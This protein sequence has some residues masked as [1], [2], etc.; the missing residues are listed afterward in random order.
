M[1]SHIKRLLSLV[2]ASLILVT[3]A[4]GATYGEQRDSSE[5]DVSHQTQLCAGAWLSETTPQSENY[6][7]YKPNTSTVPVVAYGNKL[8]G[9]S[10]Y[11][12]V[13]NWLKG[14]GETP[15]AAVNGDYFNTS[16]GLPNGIVITNGVLRG[17]DGYQYGVGFKA[18]GSILMGK[19]SV[20][21]YLTSGQLGA[22]IAGVNRALSSSGI[23]LY[24]PDF[25]ATTRSGS[26][27]LF[28]TFEPDSELLLGTTISGTVTNIEESSSAVSIPD[29]QMILAAV[30]GTSYYNTL[31]ELKKGQTLKIALTCASGW[32]KVQYACGAYQVLVENGSAASG[33]DAATAPRT[34]IGVRADGTV[35]FYTVDGRQ[36]SLSQGAG[37]KALAQ[38][39]IELGCVT[40]Y[41]LDGGGSTALGVN[42]PGKSAMET[43]NS[44]SD[45]SLRKCANFIFLVNRAPASGGA[46]MLHIYPYDCD[47]MAGA[48]TKFETY[49][50]DSQWHSVPCGA[51]SYSCSGGTID[52]EGLWTAPS[53][54]GAVS[55]RASSGSA[56]SSVDV[57]V[58]VPD[59]IIITRSG[60]SVT[61]KTITMNKG[62][63]S[64]FSV[65]AKCGGVKLITDDSLFTWTASDSVGTVTSGGVFTAS[66]NEGG[67][68]GR[69]TVSYNGVSASVTVNV[70]GV[71]ELLESFDAA[72][73]TRSGDGIS[74]AR[75]TD[76]QNVLY[77]AGSGALNYNI[78]DNGSVT[79]GWPLTLS[80]GGY[81]GLW[82]KG[83][84][85]GE[86]LR[87]VFSTGDEELGC[88]NFTGWRY[89]SC[90]IPEGSSLTG[91]SVDSPSPL[92]GT[93]WLDSVHESADGI[94]DC[95]GPEILLYSD[96]SGYVLDGG[97]GIRPEYIK[98][99]LDRKPLTFNY[100]RESGALT[101]PLQDAGAGLHLLTVTACDKYGNL[102]TVTESFGFAASAGFAD[103]SGHWAENYVN[104]LA[105]EGILTG[106]ADKGVLKARP[107]SPITR[108]EFAA[109]LCRWMGA[110][111]ASYNNYALKYEDASSIPQWALPQVKAMT[112]LSVINGSSTN[113]HLNF[114]PQSSLTR[115]EAMTMLGRTQR[116][117]YG[118]STAGYTDSAKIPA[119]AERYVA[120]LTGRGV[121]SG[122][123][124]RVNPLGN[125]T[126]AEMA[127]MLYAMG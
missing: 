10:N 60:T 66:S 45:G 100:D 111:T 35:I 92:S 85:K 115:A 73:T 19:P 40:A 69:L 121:V 91:L 71:S 25:S 27:A 17:S 126:R 51:V 105:Q 98:V 117:G 24:T 106:S 38:R 23:F 44:P 74:L 1:R 46:S 75:T 42:L 124:G 15:V 78:G 107:D 114:K 54:P 72:F 7:V 118:G 61:G 56:S 86:T 65:I 108:C 26:K 123:G 110:D 53:S 125:V 49:A 94:E 112:A 59:E 4:S 14:K 8:Y 18:D 28:V 32:E 101:V 70:P 99:T 96:G 97:T 31:S 113:G 37:L 29:G 104:Y 57:K 87:A 55:V 34:A 120:E 76:A 30:S 103:V 20:S 13:A 95:F 84:G 12:T 41:N 82:V 83:D 47:I 102:R 62:T 3:A 119:W 67:A 88:V 77:G 79:L 127:K 43:I 11:Q 39:M 9:T 68:S 16:T 116:L 50:T 64:D 80:K 52:A 89:L 90:P 81:L 93:L 5:K 22:S 2:G 122:N 21:A 109:I 6:I 33:L 36:S 58:S 48:S 63:S